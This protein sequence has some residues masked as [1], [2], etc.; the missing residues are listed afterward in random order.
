MQTFADVL[1]EHE[2]EARTLVAALLENNILELLV[3]RLTSFNEKVGVCVH[4]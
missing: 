2:D 3:Q 4:A 1:E